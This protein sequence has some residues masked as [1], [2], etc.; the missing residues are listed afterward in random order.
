MFGSICFLLGML[1]A[2][3]ALTIMWSDIVGDIDTSVVTLPDDPWVNP[4]TDGM[5][6]EWKSQGY[7]GYVVAVDFDDGCTGYMELFEDG[8]ITGVYVLVDL[9]CLTVWVKPDD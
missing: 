8:D 2:A 4:F 1:V 3:L 6:R 5:L 9:S 7:I